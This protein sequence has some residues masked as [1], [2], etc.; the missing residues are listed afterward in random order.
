MKSEGNL[1]NWNFLTV[2]PRMDLK[3]YLHL[4]FFILFLEG[5][6]LGETVLI[7]AKRFALR[8]Q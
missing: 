8:A 6:F 2:I 5:L 4:D 7:D 3:M 1:A